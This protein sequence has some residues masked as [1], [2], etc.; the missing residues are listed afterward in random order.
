MAKIWDVQV[1]V[2]TGYNI[3]VL[4]I[5]YRYGPLPNLELPLNL[6]NIKFTVGSEHA[7]PE[8]GIAVCSVAGCSII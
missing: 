7:A 5:K 6:E 3:P 8:L 2:I 1:Y 4:D